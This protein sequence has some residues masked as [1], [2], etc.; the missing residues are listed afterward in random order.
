MP[1]A[2]FIR[3]C[4]AALLAALVAACGVIGPSKDN[5][6]AFCG[7]VVPV[8][9]EWR[10]EALKP[11]ATEAFAKTIDDPNQQGKFVFFSRLGDLA[12]FEPPRMTGYSTAS[13]KGSFVR[14]EINAR[15]ANGPALLLLTLRSSDDA[16]KL[17][18]IDIRSPAFSNPAARPSAV[19][20]I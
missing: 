2:P 19:Q 3:N 10:G 12:S 9:A 7:E 17:Q 6:E 11:Y 13:G 1:P 16:L 8:I 14:V 20:Q 15:F 4:L 18:D 5:V